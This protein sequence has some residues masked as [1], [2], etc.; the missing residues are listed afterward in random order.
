MTSGP[1]TVFP[2]KQGLAKDAGSSVK[3]RL[4]A[5]LGYRPSAHRLSTTILRT[6]TCLYGKIYKGDAELRLCSKN[7][8]EVLDSFEEPR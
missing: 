5:D 6:I 2:P 8:S 3:P 4:P 1:F 7:E